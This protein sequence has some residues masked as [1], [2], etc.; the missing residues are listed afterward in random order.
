[1]FG[2]AVL[3]NSFS[4]EMYGVMFGIVSI[5]QKE[6]RGFSLVA[7]EWFDLAS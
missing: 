3:A 6:R 5:V 4:N 7:D 1:L 2:W